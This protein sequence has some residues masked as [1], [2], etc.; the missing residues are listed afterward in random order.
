M[1]APDFL[2]MIV[3]FF[4]WGFIKLAVVILL[5]LYTVFAAVIVRQENLMSRMVEIPFFPIL[6]IVALA[7]LIF[8]VAILFLALIL[9]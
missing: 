6:R 2:A 5:S 4:P 8:S 1:N 7:H 3:K 9:L